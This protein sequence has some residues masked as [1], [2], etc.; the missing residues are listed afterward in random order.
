M[1]KLT[2]ISAICFAA[3]IAGG[4]ASTSNQ[5]NTPQYPV[6]KVLSDKPYVWED[7]ISEALNIARM[8]Q[9]AGVGVGMMDYPDGT[10]ATTGR[11][12]SGMQLF[13]A[14]LGLGAS[15]LF[16]VLQMGSL[17][18]GVNSDLDWK[19]SI[20]SLVD[21][22][23]I[24][25]GSNLDFIKARDKIAGLIIDSL[26]ESIDDFEL[27]GTFTTK[28]HERARVD[29]VV[30]FRSKK[31]IEAEKHDS[32]EGVADKTKSLGLVNGYFEGPVVLEDFCAI[33]FKTSV[34]TVI[35]GADKYVLVAELHGTTTTTLFFNDVLE[36]NIDSYFIVPDFYT[37]MASD[38]KGA[39][40][41]VRLPYAKVM[42]NGVELRFEKK[43][44]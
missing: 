7:S 29:S 25:T 34:P 17:N 31:C 14:A 24:S 22:G 36:N 5:N 2:K 8:A 15:G 9:P 16:G 20:V 11:V 3:A 33:G 38:K 19:P 30:N 26:K 37:F 41:A 13:D 28:Y 4:C 32:Y 43:A 42:K 27:I 35:D 12:S 44:G 40:K 6:L 39:H 18:E 1:I 21:K 23:E 10:K